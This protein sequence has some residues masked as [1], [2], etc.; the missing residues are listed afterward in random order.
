MGDVEA[1]RPKAI[2]LIK[3]AGIQVSFDYSW[4]LVFGLVL[5]SMSAG[6]FPRY[7]PGHAYLTYWLAGASATF[8]FFASVVIHELAH[9]LV[10]VSSGIQTAGSRG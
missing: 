10:A 4:L 5:F 2:N 8:F 6:Y 9:S 3:I 7:Y 1:M